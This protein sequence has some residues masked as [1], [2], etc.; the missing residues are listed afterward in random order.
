MKNTSI[1]P[2]EL[3]SIWDELA[4]KENSQVISELAPWLK[5]LN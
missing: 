5:S 2:S 4:A 3:L 1:S